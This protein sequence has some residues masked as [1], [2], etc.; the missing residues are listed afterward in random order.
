MAVKSTAHAVW[1]VGEHPNYYIYKALTTV[2]GGHDAES[3]WGLLIIRSQIYCQKSAKLY[4]KRKKIIVIS[5][6]EIE[7]ERI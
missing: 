1:A 2:S 6:K 3:A 5:G 4:N 7:N